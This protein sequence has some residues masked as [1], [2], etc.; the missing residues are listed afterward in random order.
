MNWIR[1]FAEQ[2]K[3]G[4]L[5]EFN[6]SDQDCDNVDFSCINHFVL[7]FTD[8]IVSPDLMCIQFSNANGSR[9]S[10]DGITSVSKIRDGLWE[11]NCS[12]IKNNKK[13]WLV[14]TKCMQQ[15]KD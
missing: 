2:H 8:V 4:F 11:I 1:E 10:F 5:F 7:T 9:I 12:F 15:Y 3:N 14:R 13:K 6:M